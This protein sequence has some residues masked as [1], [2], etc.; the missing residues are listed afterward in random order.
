MPANSLQFGRWRTSQSRSGKTG[1]AADSHQPF[2]Q[3]KDAADAAS[4]LR[5]FGSTSRGMANLYAELA[6]RLLKETA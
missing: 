4:P 6:E 3:D 5:L 2:H 1:G